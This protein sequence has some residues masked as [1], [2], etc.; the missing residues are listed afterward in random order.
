[1]F[2]FQHPAPGQGG[3]P[4]G[5]FL[6][7]FAPV[8]LLIVGGSWYLGRERVEEEMALIRAAEIGNVVM[9]VRRLDDEL[10]TPLRQLRTL[11]DADALKRGVAGPDPSGI[12]AAFA[13]LIVY[14][15]HYDK[16]RWIDGDGMERVRVNNV[17]GRP[18]AQLGAQLQN[19]G[20]AYYVKETR[21]LKPGEVY[22]SPMDLNVEYG[23]VEK[24]YKPTLRLITPVVGTDGRSHGV[25]VLDVAAQGLLDA[26][27]SSLTDARDHA[28]LLNS[29]GYWLKSPDSEGEWAFMFGRDDTLA[30]RSPAAWQALSAMPSGQVELD[31]GMWTWSTVYPLKVDDGHAA[32]HIPVWLV[33]AHLPSEQLVPLQ[34]AAWRTVGFYMAALLIIYAAVAAGLAQAVV[35]RARAM[36]AAAQAQAEAEAARRLSQA[37]ER[38]RLMVEGNTNGLLVADRTGRI[39]LANSALA[40]MF[41]YRSEDL[42]EQPL[43]CLLP[44]S[45]PGDHGRMF[46]AYMANPTARPMGQGRELKGRRADGSEFPI[47]ISLSPFDENGEPFVDAFVADISDRKRVE[48]RHRRVEARLQLMMQTS[49]VGLMV[50]DDQGAIEMANPSL[51]R[52]FGYGR[53]ELFNQPLTRLIPKANAAQWRQD[54]MDASPARAPGPRLELEGVRKDGQ[55]FAILV[56]LAAFEEDG[57][58]YVQATVTEAVRAA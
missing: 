1:M 35:G 16:V 32:S 36:G 11:A 21:G 29:A 7:L 18:V 53:G 14:E 28:M 37:R 13:D 17:A 27:T 33:A 46:A 38:F 49:P 58:T 22:V 51:E 39:V 52:M 3:F 34:H 41:G 10:R 31:D 6:A 23:R 26:F 45:V 30:K 55:G 15:D 25:L 47:E 56:G 54:H 8:A 50:V 43:D 19:L 9:A 2:D 42:L 57:R 5:L 24:P 12:Q 48:Q 20:D 40:R 4:K 44:E